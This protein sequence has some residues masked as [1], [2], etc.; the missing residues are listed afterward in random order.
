[1]EKLYLLFMCYLCP[2]IKCRMLYRY[3]KSTEN[4][5]LKFLQTINLYNNGNYKC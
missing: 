3:G 4:K 1:M 2:E 5:Q